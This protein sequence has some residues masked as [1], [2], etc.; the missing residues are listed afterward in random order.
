MRGKLFEIQKQGGMVKVSVP[1]C[2]QRGEHLTAVVYLVK[3][4]RMPSPA[5]AI[6]ANMRARRCWSQLKPI[7]IVPCEVAVPNGE[8]RRKIGCSTPFTSITVRET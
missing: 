3:E 6:R 2:L 7:N 5:P 4:S 1:L 8:L